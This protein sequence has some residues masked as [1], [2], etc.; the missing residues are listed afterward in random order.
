M[1][2][3]LEALHKLLV[4][5]DTSWPGREDDLHMSIVPMG[6]STKSACLGKP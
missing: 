1:L 5:I 3:Y 6:L 4:I 2:S